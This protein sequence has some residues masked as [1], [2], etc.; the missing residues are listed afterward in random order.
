VCQGSVSMLKGWKYEMWMWWAQVGFG[1][2][3]CDWLGVPVCNL[4]GVYGWFALI[5]WQIMDADLATYMWP[6]VGH[7]CMVG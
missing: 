2:V 6:M 3:E 4:F 7:G 1:F 5:A